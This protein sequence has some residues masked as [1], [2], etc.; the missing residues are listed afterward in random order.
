MEAAILVCRYVLAAKNRSC[1][2][3]LTLEGIQLP[4]P[5]QRLLF[6]LLFL[7]LLLLG[8]K[9]RNLP[10]DVLLL[11]KKALEDALLAEEMAFGATEGVDEGFEADAAGMKG[12][13]GVLAQTLCL[14]A[15][16]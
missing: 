14:C 4:L 6:Y 15:V 8:S 7:V 9:T 16:P 1:A 10:L 12:L 2:I 5:L 3:I 13:D 11:G